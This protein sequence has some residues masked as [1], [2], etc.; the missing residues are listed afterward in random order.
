MK[1]FSSF[2]L[3]YMTK[4][5]QSLLDS[6]LDKVYQENNVLLISLFKVDKFLLK[7]TPSS[8]YFTNYKFESEKLPQFA[9]VLRKYLSQAR[10]RSI[11]QHSFER[12]VEFEF[13]KKERFILIAELF[14]SGNVI[15]C[16]KDYNIINCLH[17]QAWRHRMI[18][19]G[20]KYSYPPSNNANP[21]TLK[22]EDFKSLSK[23]SIVK[24]LAIDFNIGGL[25]A[26]EICFK[27]GVDK[28]KKQLTD[29]EIKKIISVIADLHNI[30]LKPN[31]T[32][33]N[34]LPFE[35]LNAKPNQY[36]DNFSAAVDFFDA[37][38]KVVDGA[39]V[40]KV[41]KLNTIIEKQKQ[42]VDFLKQDSLINKEIADAIYKNYAYVKEVFDAIKLARDKKIPWEEISK[43]L[44]TKGIE[45][46]QGKVML[47]L[48]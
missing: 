8:V 5:L 18:R 10:L 19:P 28:N 14:S 13:D 24:S 16:D 47:E 33:D 7:I 48:E 21:F 34:V 2:D 45:L 1:V 15:L 23:D 30:E 17:N 36:F 26:E 6:K 44:K 40:K 22:P 35:F 37:N 41:G 43:R 38:I 12:I 29:V 11:K 39:F 4:E 9:V 46:K 20:E 32:A 3:Y 31:I 27:A 25:F 42:Q